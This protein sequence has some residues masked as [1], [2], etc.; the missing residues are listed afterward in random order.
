MKM[1]D[2]SE[3]QSDGGRDVAKKKAVGVGPPFSPHLS[4]RSNFT[5]TWTLASCCKEVLELPRVPRGPEHK[6]RDKR[7][8][9]RLHDVHVQEARVI[10]ILYCICCFKVFGIDSY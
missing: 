6:S 4:S 8:D 1:R 3:T 10:R 5:F 2:E 7:T 9:C